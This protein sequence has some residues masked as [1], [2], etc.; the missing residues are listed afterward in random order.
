MNGP[1]AGVLFG[2]SGTYE[3]IQDV[4]AKFYAGERKVL[5]PD[6]EGRWSVSMADGRV[7]RTCVVLRKGRYRFESIPKEKP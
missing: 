4:I 3:G 5:T 1:R 6:G 2:S 7:L